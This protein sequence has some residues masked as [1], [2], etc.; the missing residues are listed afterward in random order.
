[1]ESFVEFRRAI[2]GR[3]TEYSVRRHHRGVGFGKI[4]AKPWLGLKC[5]VMPG[6]EA[7]SHPVAGYAPLY[8]GP[9]AALG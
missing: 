5:P 9:R 1:M 6:L 2:K 7:G 8:G 4:E 3:A